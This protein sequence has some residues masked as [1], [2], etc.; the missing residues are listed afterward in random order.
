MP[1][2]R[3]PRSKAIAPARRCAYTVLRRVFERGAYAD[4]ALRAE[5]GMLDGRDRALAAR[6]SYGAVQRRGTLDHVIALLAGREP[7]RLDAP[8][9]AALRLG[10]YE[11]LYLG[12]AP[13]YAVVADAVELAKQHGRAGH[14]L[15][16]A[17]LRRAARE[18]PALLSA[19]SDETPE[20]AA[21]KHSHPEWIA[22]LWWQELGAE[23]ARA[24]MAYD[25]EPAELALRANTLVTDAPSL[26]ARLA[27]PPGDGPPGDRPPGDGPPGDGPPGDGPP[28]GEE[29]S[30]RRG[31]VG[32]ASCHLDPQIPEAVVLESPFELHGSPLWREGAF[33]AQSRAAMLVARALEP[34]AGERVLDLCAAPG[35]KTTHLAALMEGGGE[36]VAVER[37]RARAGALART[38]RRLRAGNVRVEVA[39]AAVARTGGPEFDRVLVDPPCSGLGTLQA[40]ADLRWRATPAASTELSRLQGAILDAGARALRPGGVLVYSTCTISANENEHVIAAFLDCHRDFSLDDLAAELP[41]F[42]SAPAA[43]GAVL[44]LPHRDR[45]AGFFITRLRRD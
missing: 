10:A 39:D 16:N 18:G 11:L 2:V 5:A 21:I 23:Q 32:A 37:N 31:H 12:G 22:R 35:G 41:A 17:V 28:G 24:L 40:R 42:A 33:V 7:G 1:P 26:A 8:V 13:D 34:R 14:S 27:G 15:V 44:T 4:R 20:Q 38:A 3:T 9:L 25:N 30:G 6:L 45:T 43:P 29:R 36:V 19:L